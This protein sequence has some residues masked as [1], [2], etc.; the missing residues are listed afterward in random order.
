MLMHSIVKFSATPVYV[1]QL[2]VCKI[3]Y[4]AGKGY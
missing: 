2:N 4:F 1:Y 3:T